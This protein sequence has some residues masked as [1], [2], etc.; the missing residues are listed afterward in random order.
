[1]KNNLLFISFLFLSAYFQAQ[2]YTTGVVSL[3]STPGLVMTAKID[4]G[5]QVSLT[6]TGPSGRWFALGFDATSMGSGNDV[7]TVHAVGT[8]NAFDASIGGYSAPIADPLQHWTITSDQVANGVRTVVATRA[9]NT[10]D[11]NDHVFTAATGSLNL[12][13]ARAGSPGYSYSYHGGS[14]RGITTANFT[15]VPPPTPPAAPT[16]AASQTFCA[17]ALISQL[18]AAGTN[19]QWYSSPTGGTPLNGTSQL[20][21][22]MTYYASQTVNNLEST[23]RLAV[24]VTL[25]TAPSAP[26]TINGA[27]HFCYD[28]SESY[29]ITPVIGAASYVWTTPNGANGSSTGTALNLLF[30]PSFVSGNLSVIAQNACG[31]SPAVAININQ[32]LAYANTLNISSCIPY[33]FNGQTYTQS[34]TYPY[35]GNTIWGC[36]STVVLN[37]TIVQAYT[38]NINESACGSYNWNGQTLTQSGFYFDSLQSTSGC[39]STV[40][41]NLTIVQAYSTNVSE[42]TCGSYSWNGQTI[43]QSGLYIDTLQSAS[44]C[45][46]IVLLNLTIH[47]IES[48]QIDSTVFDSFSWNGQV[49]TT[50]GLHSQYF[51][52]IFGC[53]STVTINLTIVDSGL[54]ELAPTWN[55]YPNPIGQNQNLQISGLAPGLFQIFDVYGSIVASGEFSANIEILNIKPGIYY[56][57]I[58]Q[59]R[60]RVM[61]R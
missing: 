59:H 44:G 61:I 29:S 23:N 57:A 35:S 14:N 21:N 46:S 38:T 4:V 41:L 11:L 3:S 17:G 22:G 2:T 52:S 30:G 25:N 42:N 47:P 20:T 40:V 43:W 8:L 37:L 48:I 18:S 60:K 9:L 36:D 13:W 1:M 24:T 39:D 16:G 7:A 32:H 31:Q 56:L 58:G 45:D 15:L 10:G 53:D 49:Y 34:G 6:F 27:T 19:I 55:V 26:A 12:I 51:T 5:T 54:D 33:L 50:S 28:G